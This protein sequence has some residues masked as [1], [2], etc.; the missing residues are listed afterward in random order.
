MRSGRGKTLEMIC[1]GMELATGDGAK[2][3]MFVVPNHML[4]D[5]ANGFLKAYPAAK[6]LAASKDDL[7]LNSLQADAVK[8]CDP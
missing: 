5:F 8:D 3:V 1:A 2:K 7:S 6:V 4:L